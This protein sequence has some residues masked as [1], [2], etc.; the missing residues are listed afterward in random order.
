MQRPS[1]PAANATAMLAAC[2]PDGLP[3]LSAYTQTRQTART[4]EIAY[5]KLRQL[6]LGP[7]LRVQFENA[8]TLRYQISESLHGNH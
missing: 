7:H 5:K 8:R 3:R 4:S 1:S 2:F 6:Q